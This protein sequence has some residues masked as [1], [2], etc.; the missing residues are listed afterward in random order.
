[1]TNSN[2][3]LRFFAAA[4]IFLLT[5]FRISA[6]SSL[7]WSTFL[8]GA[9]SDEI[10]ATT[11]DALGNVYVAGYST[12]NWGSPVNAYSGG[13]DGFVAKLDSNGNIIWTTFLGG[14]GNDEA[15]GVNVDLLGNV[16]VTGLSDSTWG[17]PVRPF[18]AGE[19]ENFTAKLDPNGNLIWNTFLGS[20][21]TFQNVSGRAVAV[22]LAGDV[23]V[24]GRSS[25]EWGSPIR[26]FSGGP[27][28]AYAAK[29]NPDGS[30]AWNTFLGAGGIDEGMGIAVDIGGNAYVSGDSDAAWG[31]PIR[32][33]NGGED[34]FLAKLDPSGTLLW[35]TFLGSNVGGEG[36]QGVALDASGNVYVAGGASASWGTP[37]RPFVSG[38]DAFAAKLTS[39]GALIWN[40]FLGGN[41]SDSGMAIAVDLNGNVYTAGFSDT[42][43]GSPD[44]PFSAG[45]DVFAAK[46][47]PN[48]ALLWNTFLGGNASDFGFG[49]GVDTT[50]NVYV[51]GYSQGAWDSPLR[52]YTAAEDGFVA[53]LSPNAAPTPSPTPS[54]SPTP[55]PSATPT[56]TPTATPNCQFST[57]IVGSFNGTP[58]RNGSFVWFNSVLKPAGL[59]VTPVTFFFTQQTITSADFTLSVPDAMVTFDPSATVAT[60]I[61]QGG[62]WVTRVPA[63]DLAGN[64]FLSALV[65]QVSA[66]IPGGLKNVTWSGTITSD[67]PGTSLQWKWAAAVYTLFSSDY[68]L[69]GVKPV[70]DNKA[71]LFKNADHAG[72]PENFKTFVIGGATG[73]GG[74]NYTGSY[75]GTA[76]IGPCPH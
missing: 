65:F 70:D 46:V 60:T 6:N 5:S 2:R 4:V 37:V 76:Q 3:S 34:G 41:G 27:F 71:S 52:P 47:D 12:A 30:L 7:A 21:V 58:I 57:S 24:T 40:T 42:T 75:S 1:M 22:D 36:A 64:T 56:P 19:F 25:S 29:L 49:V 13:V 69:L 11:V 43:W 55:T 9:G 59:G 51:G 73:G 48:G 72:T 26:P 61:F 54:P 39:N 10:F 28:D 66:N 31:S 74:A 67:T 35:N 18:G 23:Y 16:Y 62:M 14:A 38:G 8:G 68:N 50:G 33:Y 44:R 45:F 32:P 20:D 53:K 17:T 15:F 63:T